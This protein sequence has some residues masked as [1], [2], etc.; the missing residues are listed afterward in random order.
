MAKK[1]PRLISVNPSHRRLIGA[2]FDI[3]ILAC[4]SINYP[5]NRLVRIEGKDNEINYYSEGS[6][7]EKQESGGEKGSEAREKNRERKKQRRKR[8]KG[9]ERNGERE[10]G[11]TREGGRSC[12]GAKVVYIG[13]NKPRQRE[14][15]M[16]GNAAAR[17]M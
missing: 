6:G 12:A 7:E 3:D 10:G 4:R 14:S 13:G 9:R 8:A 2:T 15:S 5:A 11:G 17:I 1:Q 16:R